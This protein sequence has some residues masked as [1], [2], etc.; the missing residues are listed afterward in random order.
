MRAPVDMGP[1]LCIIHLDTLDAG[2]DLEVEPQVTNE[3]E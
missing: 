2:D 1:G 3:C